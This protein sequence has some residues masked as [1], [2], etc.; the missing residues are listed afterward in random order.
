MA[1]LSNLLLVL[2]VTLDLVWIGSILSVAALL[3]PPADGVD[4]ARGKLALELY[5]RIA[6]PAFVGAFLFGAARLSLDLRLYFVQTHFMHAKL[7][8]ALVVI[9]LHHMIGAR[10][11][12]VA[13]D[14]KTPSGPVRGW[15]V[16]L[17]LGAAAVSYFAVLKPF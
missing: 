6:V 7:T 14:P 4:A 13:N 5:K 17:L 15:A 10:A 1:T 16:T 8:L 11:R 2:H 3:L 12:R 9:A